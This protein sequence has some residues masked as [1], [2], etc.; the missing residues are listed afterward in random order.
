M[1]TLSEKS[2]AACETHCRSLSI[3]SPLETSNSDSRS[4]IL[5]I[6]ST[7]SCCPLTFF[8]RNVISRIDSNLK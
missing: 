5:L 6:M 2:G 8:G 1:I 4:A 3:A 7:I